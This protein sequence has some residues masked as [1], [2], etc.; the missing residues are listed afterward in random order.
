MPKRVAD[1]CPFCGG[2]EMDTEGTDCDVWLRCEQCLAE[3]PVATLGCRDVDEDGPFDLEAEA[4]ELW[5]SRA[6]PEKG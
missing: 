1:P 2:T 3:G 6:A 4:V 5:N